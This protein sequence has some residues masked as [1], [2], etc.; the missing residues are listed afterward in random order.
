MALIKDYNFENGV[1]N[2]RAHSQVCEAS[3]EPQGNK[4]MQQGHICL[5]LSLCIQF[6]FPALIYS[7]LSYTKVASLLTNG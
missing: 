4:Q 7:A 2:G 3:P 5:L 6:S 1:L